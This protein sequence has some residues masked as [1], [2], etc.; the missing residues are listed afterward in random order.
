MNQASHSK[1]ELQPLTLIR[2]D[3]S[4]DADALNQSLTPS[5]NGPQEEDKGSASALKHRKKYHPKSV[6]LG[7][8]PGATKRTLFSPQTLK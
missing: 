5:A 6:K 3:A 7:Y 4:T 1:N 2:Y 8:I